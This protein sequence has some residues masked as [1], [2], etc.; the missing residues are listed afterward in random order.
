MAAESTCMAAI[1][2][3]ARENQEMFPQKRGSPAGRSAKWDDRGLAAVWR[4]KNTHSE[5]AF[6]SWLIYASIKAYVKRG[7]ILLIA[8]G[9]P[10]FCGET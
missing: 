4:Q 5:Q 8:A 7:A 6:C 1:V 9:E 2:S 3:G 10:R